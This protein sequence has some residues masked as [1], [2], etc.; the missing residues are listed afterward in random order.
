MDESAESVQEEKISVVIGVL[1]TIFFIIFDLL[2]LIPF[3]GDLED[4]LGAIIMVIGFVSDAG[5][6]LLATQGIVM[7]VK[8]IPALQ[9]IPAW[10]PAWLFIWYA[11]NHPSA[12]T[13]TVLKAAQTEAAMEEG[14][15]ESEGA[16]GLGAAEEAGEAT[17]A[18]EGAAAAE[19]ATTE[20][21]AVAENGAEAENAGASEIEAGESGEA[22]EN[23]A[24]NGSGEDEG[25]DK[26][27]PEEER[28]P[29]DVLQE[30]ISM[31]SGNFG[32]EDDEDGDS[33]E[34]EAA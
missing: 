8:A 13:S 15:A 30:N 9:E 12:A 23:E 24:G 29:M 22:A 34:E 19:G 2:S 5:P 17:E 27:T 4:I 20:G 26:L 32:D 1:G 6:V 18:G 21:G 14:G 33:Y 16:E 31:P 10:T 3:V 28:N 11:E 7:F 25:A